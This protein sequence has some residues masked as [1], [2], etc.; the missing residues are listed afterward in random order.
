MKVAGEKTRLERRGP[1]CP[2]E[3][4]GSIGKTT[5]ALCA[6][7]AGI[8]NDEGREILVLESP[9]GHDSSAEVA[10]EE[11]PRPVLHS[12]EKLSRVGE[13]VFPREPRGQQI[14]CEPRGK[15]KKI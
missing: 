5:V 7:S 11:E 1:E 4:S 10:L 8:R 13:H 3:I 2:A 14:A 12:A 9:A 6:V 15:S